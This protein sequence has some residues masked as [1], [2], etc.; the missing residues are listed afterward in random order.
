MRKPSTNLKIP[1]ISFYTYFYIL[2]AS[3]TIL[4]GSGPSHVDQTLSKWSP[5]RAT[6]YTPLDPWGA[7]GGT[8]GHGDLVKARYGM[9]TATFSEAL[10]KRGVACGGCFEIPCVENVRP[11][12]FNNTLLSLSLSLSLNLV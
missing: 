12:A 7:F 1:N 3:T 9:A 10:F 11:V 4:I 8:C 6:Y 5:A 2:F